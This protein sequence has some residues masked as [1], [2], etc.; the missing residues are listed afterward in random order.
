MGSG[1]V[2]LPWADLTRFT[3]T[4]TKSFE[5]KFPNFTSSSSFTLAARAA[6]EDEGG[7]PVWAEVAGEALRRRHGE[8]SE[9]KKATN[10]SD[11]GR[12]SSAGDAAAEEGAGN[13]DRSSV[14]KVRRS[15]GGIDLL[16]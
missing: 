5:I 12:N 2:R 13:L 9:M 7:E 14:G 4:F 11:R 1:Y 6:T 10:C 15:S 8:A 3:Y 16:C